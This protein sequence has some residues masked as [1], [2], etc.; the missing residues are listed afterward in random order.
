[1]QF[2]LGQYSVV[3]SGALSVR[4]IR[5]H[6]DIDIIATNEL[7]ERLKKEGWEEREKTNGHYNLHKGDVEI[8]KGFSN[9]PNCDLSTE[10]VIQNSDVI[11]GIPFMSLND[12]IKLKTSLGREKDIKDIE[13]INKYT[14]KT[15]SS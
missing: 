1:L 10:D 6:H 2:P 4:K 15:K 8:D 5:E 9:I 14:Q 3:G 11:D 13:S 7:Y 12:L